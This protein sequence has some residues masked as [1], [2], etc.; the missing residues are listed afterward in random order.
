MSKMSGITAERRRYLPHLQ[1]HEHSYGQLIL[2]LQGRLH[3]VW[4]ASSTESQQ[5]EVLYVPPHC[6]HS[7]SA[8]AASQFL[9]VDI[10]RLFLPLD[11]QNLKI[12][13]TLDKRWQA[14]RDL[15]SA[16]IPAGPA[17]NHQRATDL[18][19]YM[20]DLLEAPARSPSLEYIHQHYAVRLPLIKLAALEHYSE[21][22]YSEWL[23]N[24]TG[25]TPQ[26]YIRRLRLQK[27]CDLLLHTPYSIL[28]IAQE[29]GYESQATL[30]RLFTRHYGLSPRAFRQNN[31]ETD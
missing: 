12:R 16:E 22:Y 7:F 29:V 4:D 24:Q 31:Q 20:I 21:S 6:P 17:V 23:L 5:A 13:Y 28:R 1:S 14:L 26:N 25:Q 9:V 10:P 30:A 27:A 8:S 11:A 2:P 18:I 3:M 15:A 19:R